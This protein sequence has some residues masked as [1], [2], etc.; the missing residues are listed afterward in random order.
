VASGAA[1]VEIFLVL[2]VTVAM[3]AAV[4]L[5]MLQVEMLLAEAG[6]NP[7][8]IR[9]YF[10]TRLLPA[11]VVAVLAPAHYPMAVPDMMPVENLELHTET[12]VSSQVAAEAALLMKEVQEMAQQEEVAEAKQ[13]IVIK[14]I[15]AKMLQQIQVQEVVVAPPI[16]THEKTSW[17]VSRAT[18]PQE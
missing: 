15:M 10:I 9:Q 4:A 18:A 11:A 13:L 2:V 7:A 8:Q 5:A 12:Q 17:A 14:E 6:H 16:Q 3:P 1:P